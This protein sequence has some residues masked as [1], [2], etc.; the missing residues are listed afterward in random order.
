[1][2][3]VVS[4]Y[5]MVHYGLG[6]KCT[7]NFADKEYNNCD[8]DWHLNLFEPVNRDFSE[9]NH[10]EKLLTLAAIIGLII[11]NT[12]FVKSSERKAISWDKSILTPYDFGIMIT[13]LP[14]WEN[15]ESIYKYFKNEIKI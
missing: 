5:M 1:V 14:S 10:I 4:V 13:N 15:R 8:F 12:I 11:L 7:L 2:T 9:V 3:A 6:A